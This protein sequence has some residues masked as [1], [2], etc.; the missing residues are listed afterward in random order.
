VSDYRNDRIR[1]TTRGGG[2]DRRHPRPAASQPFRQAGGSR[3]RPA[4]LLVVVDLLFLGVALNVYGIIQHMPRPLD[5]GGFPSST[6]SPGVTA[7]ANPT[8]SPSLI[9]SASESA[10]ATQSELAT[11]TPD[12][13][14]TD[15][16]ENL[17]MFGAK[18]ADKFTGG[19]VE[20]TENSYKSHDINVTIEKK[21]QGS[22]S[23]LVTY[24][25]ADIYVRNLSNLMTGLANGKPLQMNQGEMTDKQAKR[26]NAIIAI[27]GDNYG[28]HPLGMVVRNGNFG[29][30]KSDR[31]V[32]VLSKDG[33][34]KT[35]SSKDFHM[36]DVADSAWQVWGFGPMLLDGNGKAMTKFD[37]DVN[38]ASPRTC[39]GYYEPGHYCFV[40]VDGRQPGY[41]NGMSTTQLSQ[42]FADLGCTAAYNLDGGRTTVMAFMGN[43]YNKPFAGG[44]STSDIVYVGESN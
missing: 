44:R 30:D 16:P 41:S 18:F 3:V 35:Y 2:D 7:S 14:A 28:D 29:R 21:Q 42:L 32:C 39:I 25:V 34:M 6:K 17:G 9:A 23:S 36:T 26:Y 43:I 5:T 11:A 22:G 20:Q 33:T 27:N 37:S 19:E 38:P 8:P 12:A 40:V 13:T 31:D 1:R 24:F 10:S 4:W 15:Q